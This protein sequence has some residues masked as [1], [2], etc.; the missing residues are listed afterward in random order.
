MR[1][2]DKK[3][4]KILDSKSVK[5]FTFIQ[6]VLVVLV[7]FCFIYSSNVAVLLFNMAVKQV[8]QYLSFVY[9]SHISWPVWTAPKF[10]KHIQPFH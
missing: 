6:K 5:I 3:I 1:H 9:L 4:L 2:L 10:R 7:G 8:T